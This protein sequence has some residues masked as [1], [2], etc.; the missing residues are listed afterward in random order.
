MQKLKQE[1]TC[2][3]EGKEQAFT[4]THIVIEDE[5]NSADIGHYNLP[6]AALEALLA[7]ETRPKY[8][9]IENGAFICLRAINFNP[10]ADSNDM[11]SLRIWFTKDLVIT[12]NKAGRNLRSIGEL[13]Q[14]IAANS[15]INDAGDWLCE[16]IERVTDKVSQQ[17][18]DIE[19]LTD[20]A[21]EQV[22]KELTDIDRPAIIT[23]RKDAAQ[24]KRFMVPQ[25]DAYELLQ[26][27]L[28]LINE[29]Q[30]F[31]IKEQVDRVHRMLENLVLIRERSALVLEEIRLAI[32]EKQNE[33][34]YVL[35]LVTAIF[36]PLSFLTGLFGMNVADLPGTDF[37]NAF[38]F[39]LGAMAGIGVVV[40]IV[41]KLRK[42]L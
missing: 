23:M 4:W 11:V 22:S 28:Q 2:I 26:Q 33:R 5:D 1:F 25:K 17:I 27:K 8:L 10:D 6:I 13:K 38:W 24:I 31:Q 30:K 21:E 7:E 14:T 18:E 29:V 3:V 15:E 20:L 16:L 34:M 39:L 35:S 36:L 37:P 12:A 42:W 32:S 19:D 40:F 9:P 41:M